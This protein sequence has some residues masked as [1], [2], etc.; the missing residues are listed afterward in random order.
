[1]LFFFFFLIRVATIASCPVV[2]VIGDAS[3]CVAA[4]APVSNMPNTCGVVIR[5]LLAVAVTTELD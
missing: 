3:G 4:V 5:E 1:M 2:I